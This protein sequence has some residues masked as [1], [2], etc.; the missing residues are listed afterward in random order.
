VFKLSQGESYTV[1]HS[2]S[3]SD[4]WQPW[5]GL[6][7]DGKGNLYGTTYG[8]GKAGCGAYACGVVFKLSPSGHYTVLHAFTGGGDGA[9]P[10]G[11]LYADSKGNLYG[12]TYYGGVS[13]VG[14]VF[15]LSPDGN[16]TV[17]HSF[18]GGDGANPNASLI[19]E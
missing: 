6:I 4:G 9:N 14:T 12:T 8:G 1:L 18:S 11:G 2:F 17:L 15:R 13:N 7:A 3:G 19:A 5:A 16:Y 10:I